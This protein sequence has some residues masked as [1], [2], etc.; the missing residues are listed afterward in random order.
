MSTIFYLMPFRVFEFTIGALLVWLVER[1]SLKSKLWLELGMFAG[2]AMVIY[3]MFAYS[4]K[5]LFPSYNALLP[6]FG[7]ALLIYGGEES[8]YGGKLLRTPLLVEIGKI[9][10]SLYLIHW[11]LV[12][13]YKYHVFDYGA[14]S[15]VEQVFISIV[16]LFAARLMYVY[17]EQPFRIK[18]DAAKNV[19]TRIFLTAFGSLAVT[20]LLLGYAAW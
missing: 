3:P 11:P 4:E 7:A 15:V 14:L 5:T 6:C 16:S 19:P 8:K 12:V 1:Q 2:L 13:F 17:I 20:L 10:Y 9:S 18:A